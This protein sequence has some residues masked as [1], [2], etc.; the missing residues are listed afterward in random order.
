RPDEFGNDG[1][2][3]LEHL[4]TRRARGMRHGRP[5]QSLGT[6][7]ADGHDAVPEVRGPRAAHTAHDLR[8]RLTLHHAE[9]DRIP[10]ASEL[11]RVEL[12]YPFLEQF[13][14]KRLGGDNGPQHVC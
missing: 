5:H 3:L 12:R 7:L 2:V 9:P 6:A 8:Y 14:L 1:L 13:A 11:V 10:E 4:F